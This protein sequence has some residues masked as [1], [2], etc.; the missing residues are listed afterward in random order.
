MR[1][2]ITS[3][4]ALYLALGI[5]IAAAADAQT[6]DAIWTATTGSGTPGGS[7]IT[8]ANGDVLDMTIFI[9]AGPGGVREYSN[10]A[11]SFDGNLDDELDLFP[12]PGTS[13]NELSPGFSNSLD[14][15]SLTE[16]DSSLSMSESV[17]PFDAS[18]APNPG[19][20]PFNPFMIGMIQFKVANVST[21]G[22]DAVVGFNPPGGFIFDN[23]GVDVTVTYAFNAAT[24]NAAAPPI[25]PVLGF[26]GLAALARGLGVMVLMA[27]RHFRPTISRRLAHARI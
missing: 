7:T 1:L 5:G 24:V 14:P 8:A 18:N 20:A 25:V 15:P 12:S 17:S 6:V 10:I 2:R 22:I 21:D 27:R 3:S 9:T 13:A 4:L 19:E 23:A 11:L 26:G 16:T